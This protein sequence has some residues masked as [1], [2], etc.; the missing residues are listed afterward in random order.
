MAQDISKIKRSPYTFYNADEGMALDPELLF[1]GRAE[2]K[3]VKRILACSPLTGQEHPLTISEFYHLYDIP[4]LEWT[5]LQALPYEQGLTLEAVYGF[6]RNGLVVTDSA[7]PELAALRRREEILSCE[8]WHPYSALYHMMTKW[9]GIDCFKEEGSSQQQTIRNDYSEQEIINTIHHRGSEAVMRFARKFGSPPSPF[10]EA[11]GRKS[12]TDLPLIRREGGLYSALAQ[13]RTTRSFDA[14]RHMELKDFALLLYYVYGCHGFAPASSEYTAIKKT[15]PSGGGFHPVEVYPLVRSVAGIEPG[16]YHYNVK[17]HALESIKSLHDSEVSRLANLFTAGQLY[18]S[19]A[20][21][22]FIMTTRFFRNHWKYRKNPKTYGVMLMDAAHLSQTLYLVAAELGL[23]AF[24]TA[25]INS[26]DIEGELGLDGYT[27][28]P[29]AISGAG[30][31]TAQTWDPQFE[32]FTPR[33]T[34]L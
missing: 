7:A 8:Q 20:H 12:T 10:Y 33:E 17:R 32:P 21:V 19:R 4:A 30:V 13:R 25:A 2:L 34:A 23:G 18:P 29:V 16:L 27:E 6:A 1:Q 31:P 3:Y 24:I 26:V 11:P 22:L 5:D 15:S 28:S 14:S 9:Q